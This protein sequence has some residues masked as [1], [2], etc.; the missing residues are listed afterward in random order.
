[1]ISKATIP[2]VNSV[3]LGEKMSLE[4]LKVILNFEV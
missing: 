1:M 3:V 4:M 2:I